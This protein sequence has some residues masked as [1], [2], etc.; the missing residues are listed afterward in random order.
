M[1]EDDEDFYKKNMMHLIDIVSRL[2]QCRPFRE[3]LKRRGKREQRTDKGGWG[4]F[5]ATAPPP[6]DT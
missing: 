1:P 5:H 4:I 2:A 3:R 6:L